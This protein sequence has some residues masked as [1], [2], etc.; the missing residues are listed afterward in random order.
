MPHI[1]ISD[2]SFN[3]IIDFKYKATKAFIFKTDTST[4][5]NFTDAVR[6]IIDSIKDIF[7]S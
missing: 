5:K 1:I 4:S 3:E 7:K 2:E 6:K